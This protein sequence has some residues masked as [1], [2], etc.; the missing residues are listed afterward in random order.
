M[1]SPSAGSRHSSRRRSRS[2]DPSAF[3]SGLDGAARGAR[4]WVGFESGNEDRPGPFVSDGLDF[5]LGGSSSSKFEDTWPGGSSRSKFE[6]KF[7]QPWDNAPIVGSSPNYLGRQPATNNSWSVRQQRWNP[8][9][10]I[11]RHWN[12]AADKAS[13]GTQG[14]SALAGE[15][16][17]S[18]LMPG[19]A[20]P[21]TLMRHGTFEREFAKADELLRL[22]SNRIMNERPVQATERKP[23]V[24]EGHR[25]VE[26]LNLMADGSLGF[27]V[28]DM[29]IAEITDP[30]ASACGWAFGDRILCVNGVPIS[31]MQELSREL[32]KA[33]QGFRLSSRPLIFDIWRHSVATLAALQPASILTGTN[34]HTVEVAPAQTPPMAARA[35]SVVVPAYTVETHPTPGATSITVAATPPRAN[36]RTTEVVPVVVSAACRGASSPR[37][38]PAAAPSAAPTVVVPLTAAG[39]ASPNRAQSQLSRSI[40]EVPVETLA[41][42]GPRVP[43]QPATPTAAVAAAAAVVA[44]AIAAASAAAVPAAATASPPPP[45]FGRGAAALPTTSFVVGGTPTQQQQQHS[46]STNTVQGQRIQAYGPDG[47]PLDEAAQESPN[48]LTYSGA[49]QAHVATVAG[50]FHGMGLLTLPKDGRL[51]Y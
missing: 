15:L 22:A 26:M 38:M 45:S 3:R 34:R 18:R 36:Q 32:D 17:R 43:L 14:F 50:G 21:S 44:P 19:S 5:G 23:M 42:A 16:E 24:M 12:D 49:Q 48:H 41:P 9:E 27:I 7:G 46:S 40:I 33:V 29:A 25:Q 28:K 31:T 30:Q 1:A 39:P 8:L 6:D 47:F 10:N 4:N 37:S 35:A 51:A 11:G 13:S 2:S 20:K